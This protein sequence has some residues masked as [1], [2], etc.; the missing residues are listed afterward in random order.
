L[1]STEEIAITARIPRS[2]SKDF[3]DC[4]RVGCSVVT[5]SISKKTDRQAT[6][7]AYRFSATTVGLFF[8]QQIAAAE[9]VA[10]LSVAVLDVYGLLHCTMRSK[11]PKLETLPCGNDDLNR[12]ERTLAKNTPTSGLQTIYSDDFI[13]S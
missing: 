6:A 5:S 9:E 4:I 13:T 7:Q 12:K 8:D 2:N 10:P 3:C 11:L 1:T